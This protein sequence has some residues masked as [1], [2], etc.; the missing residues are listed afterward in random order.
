[1]AQFRDILRG[2]FAT[3]VAG[4]LLLFI[5]E[6]PSAF[7]GTSV[8]H[9]GETLVI[10]T[11]YGALLAILLTL[12]VL[13]IWLVLATLKAEVIFPVAPIVATLLISI[14]MIAESGLASGLLLAVFFG[15]FAG[16][17]FWYWAFG[18]VWQVEMGF[19]KEKRAE[20]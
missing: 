13:A 20:S 2:C 12:I 5:A 9:L 19:N 14:P 7:L 15:G 17:H 4:T 6:L 18:R 11:F 16:I 10:L 1:V 8:F 3:Y